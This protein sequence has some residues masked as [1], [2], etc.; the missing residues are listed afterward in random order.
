MLRPSGLDV[1]R[2]LLAFRDFCP[3]RQNDPRQ[4]ESGLERLGF[5]SE[6]ASRAEQSLVVAREQMSER[7][8][9]VEVDH[10]SARSCASSS[11]STL[12]VVTGARAGTPEP[13]SRGS[14]IHPGA[15]RGPGARRDVNRSPALGR[16][17]LG[18][19]PIA[20]GDEDRFPARRQA[21]V[22]AQTILQDL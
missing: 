15:R 7:D 5:D 8:R 3:R 11:K 2:H 9:A 1:D 14:V 19:D 21:H 10:R 16:D 13:G 6:P 22:L 17:E 4:S 20:I 18:H 12:S